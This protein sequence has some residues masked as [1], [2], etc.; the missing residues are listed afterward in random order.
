MVS[1][2]RY[3]ARGRAVLRRIAKCLV[4]EWIQVG[5]AED[6][7]LD[8]L[9]GEIESMHKAAGGLTKYDDERARVRVLMRGCLLSVA[10]TAPVELYR[11]W[12]GTGLSR[13]LVGDGGRSRV[14][15]L[16]AAHC[17]F[18]RAALQHLRLSLALAQ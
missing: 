18:S 8:R 14:P 9:G 15:P 5:V 2:Q 1:H 16:V 4:V 12:M 10:L 11:V 6:A 17:W 3:D 13:P 7:L